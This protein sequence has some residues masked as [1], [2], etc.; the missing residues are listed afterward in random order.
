MKIT[1]VIVSLVVIT[2]AHWNFQRQD[3][4]SRKYQNQRERVTERDNENS[5][6]VSPPATGKNNK[7]SQGVGA[8]WNM[9]Q[10]AGGANA[11]QRGGCNRGGSNN[12]ADGGLS[13]R[14]RGRAGGS[15]QT[16]QVP[17][18]RSNN[19]QRRGGSNTNGGTRG[20]TTSPERSAERS[21][22]QKSKNNSTPR[23]NPSIGQSNGRRQ[24]NSTSP[25]W[26]TT[27]RVST[28]RN[29]VTF[30]FN[31]PRMENSGSPNQPSNP[32]SSGEFSPGT[33]KDINVYSNGSALP[34]S[35]PYRPASPNPKNSA[36]T[37]EVPHGSNTTPRYS[38]S[39][40][41][42][43]NNSTSSGGSMQW[44][45]TTPASPNDENS[46]RKSSPSW[47]QQGSWSSPRPLLNE[48]KA[49]SSGPP[50]ENGKPHPIDITR[51]RPSFDVSASSPLGNAK[52]GIRI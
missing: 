11:A 32:K 22:T 20:T 51:N 10:R 48:T 5:A 30:S 34:N 6:E 29:N 14:S 35:P 52:A 40:S 25:D 24:N 37:F 43:P 45:T 18:T 9:M 17:R 33:S 50:P 1:I 8:W 4:P 12:A 31:D 16:E 39:G 7:R 26:P 46:T 2:E 21:F 3:G 28:P 49:H 15:G 23:N 13:A 41:W 47:S 38:G 44:K 19:G 36:G 42:A 27:E